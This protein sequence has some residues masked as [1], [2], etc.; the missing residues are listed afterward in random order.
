MIA[1]SPNQIEGKTN[2][3][4]P[5]TIC[6]EASTDNCFIC[7][8][9][10]I[11]NV[12]RKPVIRTIAGN[13]DSIVP[14]HEWLS[15]GAISWLLNLL[16]R[17]EC[18]ADRRLIQTIPIAGRGVDNDGDQSAEDVKNDPFGTDRI[19]KNYCFALKPFF[20]EFNCINLT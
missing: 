17:L 10:R 18:R 3:I 14:R 9:R 19:V 1:L 15:P 7:T 11:R 4:V 2:I 5:K 13:E 20:T 8:A 12:R 6:S 16:L